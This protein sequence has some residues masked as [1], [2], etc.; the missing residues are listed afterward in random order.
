MKTITC[1]RKCPQCSTLL[2]MS[3]LLF[4]TKNLPRKCRGCNTL[5]YINHKVTSVIATLVCSVGIIGAILYGM[6]V[7]LEKTLYLLALFCV[8]TLIVF[9]I[10]SF[11][12]PVR[13]MEKTD[14]DRMLQSSRYRAYIAFGII[15]FSVAIYWIDRG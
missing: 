4:S 6:I 3:T 10:E 9:I 1:R 15:A 12:S 14:Y 5:I 8:V 11:F 2:T 13:L 7:G